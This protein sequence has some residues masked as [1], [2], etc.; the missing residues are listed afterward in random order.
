MCQGYVENGEDTTVSTGSRKIQFY[1]LI[2]S[3]FKLLF[4]Y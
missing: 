1:F 3:Y 4:L 2:N